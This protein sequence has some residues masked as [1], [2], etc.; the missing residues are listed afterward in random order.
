MTELPDFVRSFPKVL[1]IAAVALFA[2]YLANGLFEI[3]AFPHAV[4]E[5][6]GYE[7]LLKSKY[8]FEATREC[9]YMASAGAS[10][11]VLIAIFDKVKGH[12]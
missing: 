9:L 4:S 1:Y 8:F 5:Y 7:G 3:S 12:D 6:E 2:W 11:Q 10:L